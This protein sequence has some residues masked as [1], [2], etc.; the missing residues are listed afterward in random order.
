[1]SMTEE[2]RILEEMGDHQNLMIEAKMVGE[3]IMAI[4]HTIKILWFPTL[5]ELRLM[6]PHPHLTE[7]ALNVLEGMGL[8]THSDV[9][10]SYWNDYRPDRFNDEGY[11]A[12][13]RTDPH[14]IDLVMASTDN[15]LED[16]TRKCHEDPQ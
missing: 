10:D 11:R 9:N 3:D 6:S 12:V 4:V 15:N 13:D 16:Q 8:I 5:D 7:Y 1:M 14:W 2:Y